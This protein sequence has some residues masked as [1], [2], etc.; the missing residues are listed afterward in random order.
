MAVAGARVTF[1]QATPFV[2]PND[3]VY[4][5]IERLAAAGLID[6]LIIGARPFSEREIMRLLGEAR[7]S[8]ARKQSPSAW[9]ARTIARDMARFDGPHDR[10]VDAILSGA[11]HL[12]SP[13]RPAPPDSNGVIPATINPLAAYREGRPLAFGETFEL[14]SMHSAEP[15][16]YVALTANPRVTFESFRSS[17]LVSPS[18]SRS[19]LALQSGAATFVVGN[20]SLE[21]GRDY[22]EFGQAPTGGLLLSQNAPA[23]DMIR[24]SNDLP[25]GLP[26]VSRLLGPMRGMLFVADL[27]SDQLHPH[28]KLV[29]YH[30][31]A[32]PIPQFEIGVEVID[33]MGGNGG[34]PASFGDRV[35]DA[36]PIFDVLRANSDFQFSNKIAAVDGHWREPS[37]RGFELYLQTAIDDFDAR[38]LKS[39]LLDDGGYLGGLSFSCLMDC[40]QLGVR[41]EYHQ[42]GIRFYAHPDYPIEKDSI[43]LGDPL[44]P[45]GLGGYLTVD[46]ESERAGQFSTTAAFEVRSGDGYGSGSTGNHTEGFHFFQVFHRPAEKRARLLEV[47]T[48]DTGHDRITLRVSGGAER[49]TN[50]AFVAGADRTNWIGSLGVSV[51]P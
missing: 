26:F 33:A 30:V 51:R 5:V 14:E 3:R 6:T 8:L 9:A 35:L 37:W 21:A 43:L 7:R 19:T 28:T 17:G 32:L 36:I 45:R 15:S 50:Y 41:L 16:R 10:V 24:V 49:V 11:T 34:Q 12:D 31:A 42:T 44:G 2:A 38:R 40:G 18:G 4:L 23:L 22:V 27:G 29:G 25:A 39:V 20:F 47:W 13:Y 46:A 48:F 1:A